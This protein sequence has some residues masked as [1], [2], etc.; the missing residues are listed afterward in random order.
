MHVVILTA[1]E[2]HMVQGRVVG[3]ASTFACG[4]RVRRR[5][6]C[7]RG[8]NLIPSPRRVLVFTAASTSKENYALQPW[9]ESG[10]SGIH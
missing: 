1:E 5:H 6:K 7:P 3:H 10:R 4:R 9:I 2:D 8:G